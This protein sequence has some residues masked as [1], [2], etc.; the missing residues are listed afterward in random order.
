MFKIKPKTEVRRKYKRFVLLGAGGVG[1]STAIA[2]I[3]KKPLVIDLDGRFPASL[4][5]KSDVIDTA[6]DFSGFVQTLNEILA[7]PKLDH[8]WLQIDTATKVMTIVEDWTVNKNCNGLKETYNAYGFG[9]KFS[10]MYFKEI[11]DTVDEIQ[12]K[13]GINVAFVCHSKVRM[14]KNPLTEDYS[15]NVL[16]LPDVVADRLKQWA[17]YVGY[18]YFEVEVDKEKKKASGEPQRFISFTESPLYEAK[19]S[20]EFAI[21]KRLPFDKEGVWAESIFGDTQELLLELDNL[22]TKFPAAQRKLVE[23]GIESTGVR[24]FGVKALREFINAGKEQ[25]TKMKGN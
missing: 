3:A 9:L 20:S 15:K 5:E 13:H 4:V 11:L 2:T 17:D 10:P 18:A 8:D 16:D 21:P 23:D 6:A 7:A 1:K 19:N 12:A 24:Q 14:V 25:L 22:L